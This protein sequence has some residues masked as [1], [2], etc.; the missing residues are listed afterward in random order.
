MAGCS[1]LAADAQ[2][3][4]GLSPGGRFAPTPARR[5]VPAEPS[6]LGGRVTDTV[7]SPSRPTTGRRRPVPKSAPRP[8]ADNTGGGTV[9]GAGGNVTGGG[10]SV[11]EERKDVSWSLRWRPSGN[12]DRPHGSSR[13][14]D[15]RQ[16]DRPAGRDLAS[17]PNPH[18]STGQ[19][20]PLR[21]EDRADQVD[22]FADPFATDEA[23]R[24]E[25]AHHE[26]V[27]QSA[28]T[29]K[30]R[31]RNA[32]GSAASEGPS[33]G[34][35]MRASAQEELSSGGDAAP[36]SS[37]ADDA[38]PSGFGPAA[39]SGRSGPEWE[40]EL[41]TPRR[42]DA[43]AP[44]VERLESPSDLP[45]TD[46]G[47]PDAGP[48]PDASN[49]FASDASDEEEPMLVPEARQRRPD[50]PQLQFFDEIQPSAGGLSCD[51]FRDKIRERTIRQVSLDISP[52]FRPDILDQAEYEKAKADFDDRQPIRTWRTNDGREL[53]SGRLRDLAYEKAIIE[54]EYGTTEEFP[55]NRLSEADLAYISDNWGLPTECVIEQ[56]D[57]TPRN[58]NPTTMTWMAS[59]LHHYPLYFEE[60]NL[61]RY[62]HTAGPILQPVISSAH[63]FANIAV[64]P[65]KMGTHLPNERQ[66]AL[67]YYRPGNCAPWILPP[68]PLSLRGGLTQA[69]AMTGG[70]LLIP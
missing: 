19:F 22:Y 9:A 32:N 31:V 53:G 44:Q 12:V 37:A 48:A 56:V 51:D 39:E 27:R 38:P 29:T 13:E 23:N 26:P 70:F 50:A 28:V 24:N 30:S 66:Y 67:G 7:A 33:F 1:T 25:V 43:A 6:S 47:R 2:S 14:P 64:L 61:E 41:P 42:D 36:P 40:G 18:A 8:I 45:D 4:G 20:N 57:F 68:V 52:P 69:A 17:A 60:V 46:R 35:L 3:P 34:E 21:A 59:N 54:T 65:Y 63:F 16:A 10:R 11:A 5:P 55:M 49:P 15:D 62:G 58:W